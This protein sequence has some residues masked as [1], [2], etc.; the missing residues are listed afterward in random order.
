MSI[1]MTRKEVRF[2]F[3]FLALQLFILPTL[4]IY[5]NTLLPAPLPSVYL[6][7]ILFFAEFVLAIA[8]FH[9]F[10]ILCA[11]HSAASIFRTLRYAALG[12]IINYLASAVLGMIISTFRPDFFNPNDTNIFIM[13]KGHYPMMIIATVLFAPV[14]E[15][16]LYRGLIF[17]TLRQYNRFAAYAICAFF[18][19]LIHI[20]GYIDTFSIGFLALSF[21]QYLPAG[22]CLAWVY[23]KADSIWAPILMHMAINQISMM[24]TR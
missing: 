15:E 22:L 2:G 16:L 8:I 18:F 20:I 24:N 1:S 21:L 9:R 12:F 14:T 13:A 10:L 7:F 17:G 23:E 11:K 5:L 6:N 4:L 3:V 19:G